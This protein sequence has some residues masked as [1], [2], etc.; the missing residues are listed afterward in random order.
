M[1]K[2]A[3]INLIRKYQPPDINNTDY[4][5]GKEP[6]I[7]SLESDAPIFCDNIILWSIHTN[8]KEDIRNKCKHW[9]GNSFH[10]T[11]L[12]QGN[13]KDNDIAPN[14]TPYFSI[15]ITLSEV[16]LEHVLEAIPSIANTD[17]VIIHD[18]DI[19]QDINYITT[20]R[21]V[22]E[23]IL[24]NGV[25]K[26]D[27]VD[28]RYK[29][30][31]N[32][33][34]FFNDDR[35]LK[36]K[37]Y[38][39]YVQMLESSD[40]MT[41]LGSRLHNLFVDP[42]DSIRETLERTRE[43][44]ITRIEVKFYGGDSEVDYYIEKFNEVKEF[45]QGCKFYEVSLE[46][47]WKQLAKK[48]Y[49]S[50]I[51]MIYLEEEETFAYCHWWNSLTGKMQGGISTK[52]NNEEVLTLVTNFSFNSTI[53][54]LITI[55]KNKTITNEYKRT[56]SEITFIPGPQ[57]GLYPNTKPKI[58]PS[59]VGIIDY[60]GINIGYPHTKFHRN[61]SPI[62]G[63]ENIDNDTLEDLIDH[64]ISHYTTGYNI[65]KQGSIYRVVA[66][67]E[68]KFRDKWYIGA[69]LIDENNKL[70]K[71]RCGP[72]LESLINSQTIKFHFKVTS[73]VE[74]TSQGKDVKV[75]KIKANI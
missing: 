1:D 16:D 28:D 54:K 41:T 31:D 20:R 29:V 70:I 56:A 39:K 72:N 36:V 33:I 57:G 45:L 50:K 75:V 34:S 26:R 49:K 15:R 62:T 43:T 30:G 46:N 53:T 18:I 48:I 66:R 21:N 51:T 64:H 63:L 58:N 12:R 42:K 13:L 37:V 61:S 25:Q 38:N 3:L 40:V 35:T 69:E 6:F 17:N 60:K 23:H 73:N 55:T 22:E 8:V 2:S 11:Q 67:G 24:A 68:I 32:C 14:G 27:I 10:L 7:P 74:R 65:L 9:F 44:G 5:K 4:T 19:A 47:Q 52:V 59:E 71:V